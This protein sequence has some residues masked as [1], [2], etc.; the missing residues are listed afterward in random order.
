M[1]RTFWVLFCSCP[2]ISQDT[3]VQDNL[4][5]RVLLAPAPSNDPGRMHQLMNDVLPLEGA[6]YVGCREHCGGDSHTLQGTF[7][8]MLSTIC[9]QRRSQSKK[10]EEYG[11]LTG[12]QDPR[13]R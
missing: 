9:H 12:I 4:Y 5:S 7:V 10:P 2:C 11:G 6:E 13:S 1:K 3:P 8:H